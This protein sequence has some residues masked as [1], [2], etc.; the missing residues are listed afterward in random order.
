MTV[1]SYVARNRQGATRRG[2]LQAA[3]REVLS[4]TLRKE[5]WQLV[6]C[7]AAAEATYLW[8]RVSRAEIAHLT[9][10]LAVLVDTGINLASALAALAEQSDNPAIRTLLTG[11]RSEVESGKDFSAALAQYPQYFDRTFV[12]LIK[13][14]E[15]TGT[16]GAMLEQLSNHLASDLENR[17]KVRAAMAYP[18]VMFVLAI[19]VT[20]F[21]LTYVMP[22]F[23]PLFDRQG[24]KLP[25]MTLMMLS[26][27]RSLTGYWW[28]WLA[29]IVGSITGFLYGRRTA[30]GRQVVDTLKIHLPVIGSL[31]RKVILG[32][33]VRTLGLMVRSGVPMLDC[34]RLCS[35]V[36]GNCHYERLWLAVLDGVTQGNRLCDT[37]RTSPLV[38]PL[39]VQMIAS[40]EESGKLDHVLQRVSQH[41]EREV[42]T[43]IK[44]ATSLIE[45]I[46][47]AVMGI[48]VGGIA[49]S[50]LLPIFSLSRPGH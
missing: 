48:V 46:M 47:I 50:L 28:V 36:S 41:Y 31:M 13:A 3:S 30:I 6:E 21:L 33:A 9:S 49:M 43:A 20:V 38:P 15:K 44:T 18:M 1:F 37:L 11:L 45:P 24:G 7:Q 16:L 40:G 26:L 34:L 10:Q 23:Q 27:S 2:R 14:S 22:K 17:R 32:R 12:A 25:R 19:V 8:R 39:L 4:A 29:A 35:E 5:G 42:D